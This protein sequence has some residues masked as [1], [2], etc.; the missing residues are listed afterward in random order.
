MAF[1]KWQNWGSP[2]TPYM[3]SKKKIPQGAMISFLQPDSRNIAQPTRGLWG[4]MLNLPNSGYKT[5][6]LQ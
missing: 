5:F 6:L 3:E 2:F 4:Y 1:V